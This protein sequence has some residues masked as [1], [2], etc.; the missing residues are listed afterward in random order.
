MTFF[1]FVF[2]IWVF[3][4]KMF[5]INEKTKGFHMRYHLFLHY[6]WFLQNLGK[7]FIPTNMHTTVPNL[8]S[9]NYLTFKSSAAPSSSEASISKP[10]NLEEAS[11]DKS[12]FV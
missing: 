1:F 12:G 2:G 8:L 4:K 3:Q 9:G 7:D 11:H 5:F 6:G 10:E